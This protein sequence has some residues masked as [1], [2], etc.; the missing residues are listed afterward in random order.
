MTHQSGTLSRPASGLVISGALN[1]AYETILTRDALAFVED[2]V[3]RFAPRVQ[4]LLALRVARQSRLDAG[5]LPDFLPETAAVRSGDWQAAPLPPALLDRRVEITG[6]V[7]R[8]MIIN[9]LNSGARV[10]MADFEDASTPTWQVMMEG[11]VNVRDAAAGN[12]EWTAPNGRSYRLNPR[13]AVLMVR[14]RGWHMIESHVQVDG[15]PV[16]AALWDFGLCLFH[17]ARALMARGHGPYFYLPKMQSHLEARLW[18]EVFNHAQNALGLPRGTIR[19]T[20]LIE[21]ILAAFEMDEILY[22]LREHAAGLN[23]GRW[24]FIFS[25]IKCFRRQPR[26]VLPDRGQISMAT[27]FLESYS[28]LLIQT[29]HR[30]GVHAMGGMAAQ[31]PIKNDPAANELAMLKVRKDKE[32]EAHNGHDGSWVSHPALV[33]LCEEVFNQF[34]PG[35]NQIDKKLEGLRITRDDLL[36]VPGGSITSRGL[37]DNVSA[38]LRYTESWLSGQGAVPLY[39]LMEDAATAEIARAQLWQWCHF[40]GGKLDDGRKITVERVR[41]LINHELEGIR[42]QFG[43]EH[44]GARKYRLAAQLLERMIASEV[45]PDFLTLEAYDYLER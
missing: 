25:M 42:L 45:L 1:P 26:F 29:C 14:P 40:P 24:D 38:A 20:V 18:N 13:T 33:P 8:K 2:L 19:C 41:E 32:R 34:M 39:N 37:M 10:F 15:F 22:E 11:Q 43:D 36:Q 12:I 28:L 7:D 9:G 23:C 31:I 17:N 3:R 16:P 21:T 30:R 5:E 6:P 4:E 35:P 27:H 44:F